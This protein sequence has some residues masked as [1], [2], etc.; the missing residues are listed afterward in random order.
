[1]III[2]HYQ[3][4]GLEVFKNKNIGIIEQT[5][6][7]LFRRGEVPANFPGPTSPHHP[8]P[9]PILVT[10]Q[11]YKEWSSPG[12]RQQVFYISSLRSG[13]LSSPLLNTT[14]QHS[15]IMTP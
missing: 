1:M 9:P 3:N 15:V 6:I 14:N 8:T 4:C 10:G 13:Q 7:Y 5:N 11:S 2:N 12:A